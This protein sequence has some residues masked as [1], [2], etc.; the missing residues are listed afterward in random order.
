MEWTLGRL[1]FFGGI[2]GVVLTLTAAA[3]VFTVLKRSK[4]N[5]IQRLNSEYGSDLK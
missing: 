5:I 4:K 3:V 2:A 1:L